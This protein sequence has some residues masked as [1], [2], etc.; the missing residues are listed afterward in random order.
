MRTIPW[1]TAAIFSLMALSPTQAGYLATVG[2]S[3][4]RFQAPPPQLLVRL[5]PLPKEELPPPIP[6][7]VAK[8]APNIT[9]TSQSGDFTSAAVLAPTGGTNETAITP[10]TLV[11]FFRQNTA[12]GKSPDNAVVLPLNFAPPAPAGKPSSTSTYEEQ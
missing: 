4:L 7:P 9:I 8:E 1:F 11:Q 3:P 5:P 6:M 10:E 12:Q 2:P